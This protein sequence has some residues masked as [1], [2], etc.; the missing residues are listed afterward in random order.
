LLFSALGG[1]FG[2]FGRAIVVKGAH[3]RKAEGRGQPS[4]TEK[5]LITIGSLV[6]V[7]FSDV[8]AFVAPWFGPVSVYW[9]TFIAANL[10]TNM[11]LI[12]AIMKHEKFDKNSQ[13][14]TCVIIMAVIYVPI[15][16]PGIQE[17]QD[18]KELL[19]RNPIAM[20]W[21]SVLSVIYCICVFFMLFVD[22]KKKCSQF[23]VE[24][25]F[26]SVA[27]GSSTLS[28]TSSKAASTFDGTEAGPYRAILLATT[29]IIMA[30]WTIET[31][32]EATAVRSLAKFIPLTTF[33]SLLLNGI[34]GVSQ[35]GTT[36][37]YYCRLVLKMTV[38]LHTFLL[39]CAST[40]FYWLQVIVWEDY[41]VVSSWA[42][43]ITSYCLITLGIYL[44]SDLD[45]FVAQA[46]DIQDYQSQVLS[47]GRFFHEI[48][49]DLARAQLE[50][51]LSKHQLTIMDHARFQGLK[52]GNS[53]PELNTTGKFETQSVGE[54]D[55]FD[56]S[57]FAKV[58]ED[59]ITTRRPLDSLDYVA[60]SFRDFSASISEAK[61]LDQTDANGRSVSTAQ[62]VLHNESFRSLAPSDA[63]W[64]SSW[65]SI[66][67]R[68]LQNFIRPEG[69][70]A[71]NEAHRGSLRVDMNG[72]IS[73]LGDSVQEGNAEE[74]V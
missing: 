45:F 58:E 36:P 25:V 63:S 17:N 10:L 54:D 61:N 11:L 69:T 44:I 12:G 35:L 72:F 19:L 70:S 74:E 62:K 34:T 3:R 24:L 1:A 53:D 50:N 47:F 31:Y 30:M 56:R 71:K 26:F 48:E 4:R 52:R 49:E 38:A 55:A 29:W 73:T 16:G 46:K 64:H 59:M 15:N 37:L 66:R 67:S 32:K 41:K 40:G 68:N 8:F 13:I 2:I 60:K 22:M 6:M 14:A 65:R 5:L 9:P 20:I 28:A 7:G 18:A 21:I 27:I 33:G 51:K 39:D 43:Y 42:G 23:F 57:S